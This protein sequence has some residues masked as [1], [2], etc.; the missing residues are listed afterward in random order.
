M[1]NY[2]FFLSLTLALFLFLS[3]VL[4]SQ[5]I[6]LSKVQSIA[7]LLSLLCILDV[8]RLFLLAETDGKLSLSLSLLMKSAKLEIR[9]S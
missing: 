7:K 8:C 2:S 4:V 6:D 9:S 3:S 5:S 1:V